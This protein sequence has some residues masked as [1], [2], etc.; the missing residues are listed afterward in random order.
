MRGQRGIRK[1]KRRKET[2]INER[3][4]EKMKYRQTDRQTEKGGR[5]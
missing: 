1:E 4:R 5:E 3:H 2:G